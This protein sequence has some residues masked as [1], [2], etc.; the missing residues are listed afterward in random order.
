[1]NMSQYLDTRYHHSDT[2]G[3]GKELYTLA[4][5][6]QFSD[7]NMTAYLNY[8][9]Q[10]YWNR[11]ANDTYNV[12]MSR[13]FDV[14]RFKNLSLS[15]SAY[16]TQYNHVNDDGMYMSLSIPWGNS[17]TLSY[18]TQLSKG[19]TNHSVGYYDRI[20][21]NTTY[22]INGAEGKDGSGSGSVYINHEGEFAE[23]SATVGFEGNKYTS[24]ATSVRGGMTATANG[25]ALHRVNAPGGTRML[26]DTSGVSNVP[27]RGYGAPTWS[28]TF[29]KA[30]V[31]DISSYYRTS[32]NVDLDKLGNNIEATRSVVQDT[33]TEVAIGYRKFGVIAGQKTMAILKLADGRSPPFGATVLNGDNAQTGLV[34][35][36][37]SVWLSGINEGEVMRVNW[38]GKTQCQVALPSQLPADINTRQ[39][40][41]PCKPVIRCCD[42]FIDIGQVVQFH[43]LMELV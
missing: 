33:L 17:G 43:C 41:L 42:F 38:D 3:A 18:D 31:S 26:V 25:A 15:L 28:N 40:L 10:T 39:L 14:G 32:V 13:Y 37:G 29:G 36:G 6:Q 21:N 2:E 12:S 9:H 7:L 1:M 30:V 23:M 24:L 34:T 11:P 16:R 35:D 5:N 27:V 20:N 4:F 19:N 8:S 22:R